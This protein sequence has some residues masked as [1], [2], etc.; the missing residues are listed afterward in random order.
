MVSPLGAGHET[1]PLSFV[2]GGAVLLFDGDYRRRPNRHHVP[3][4]IRK[5]P[6][7]RE[8][9]VNRR[10]TR[11]D[12]ETPPLLTFSQPPPTRLRRRKISPI[13]PTSPESAGLGSPETG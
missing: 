5:L 7:P 1:A 12:A 11:R 3:R 6:P 10:P 8:F 4:A 9:S 2:D 13:D